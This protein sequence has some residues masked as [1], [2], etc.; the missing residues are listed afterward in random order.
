VVC[1]YSIQVSH[2]A[3]DDI[4]WF[5][6]TSTSATFSLGNAKYTLV[7]D[8]FKR[9]E[10]GSP[11]PRFLTPEYSVNTAFIFAR[12][13]TVCN[14]VTCPPN[15][16]F[17]G[18]PTCACSC[19]LTNADCQ[20]L[21]GSAWE[22][23]YADCSCYCAANTT[24]TEEEICK[25]EYPETYSTHSFNPDRCGCD[26][27]LTDAYC[28]TLNPLFQVAP[29]PEP[30]A[31]QCSASIYEQCFV[32]KGRFWQPDAKNSCACICIVNDNLCVEAF[33]SGYTA[34][35]S[36]CGCVGPSGGLT[37][38]QI[39]GIAI[40][41]AAG[42]LLLIILAASLM[43]LLMCL[44]CKGVIPGIYGVKFEPV[45]LSVAQESPFYRDRWT[46]S[47]SNTLATED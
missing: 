24:A 41:S 23:D 17:I 33:G 46:V 43:A 19:A 8:G 37:S 44:I 45:D 15:S 39:A 31:C 11:V 4:F 1:D 2:T 20:L 38:G 18:F 26:C 42:A 21:F 27:N 40:G 32:N 13:V 28:Q 35:Y 16:Q 25:I 30:C 12:L 22:L 3:C 5:G 29:A 10:T 34:Q 36:D 7:V 9:N 14:V 47:R 6:T